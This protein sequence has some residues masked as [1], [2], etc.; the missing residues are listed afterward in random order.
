MKSLLPV[1]KVA[2][3]RLISSIKRVSN[4]A[5]I[6]LVGV[7][8]KKL[9]DEFS[10]YFISQVN[11]VSFHFNEEILSELAYDDTYD[12]NNFF[13]ANIYE[14]KNEKIIINIITEKIS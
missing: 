2:L 6:L 10:D 5:G 8:T 11:L 13:L 3:K 12:K 4:S 14:N 9:A 1:D 7:D